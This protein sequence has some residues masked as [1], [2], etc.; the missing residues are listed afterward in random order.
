MIKVLILSYRGAEIYPSS[1]QSQLS[2]HAA[3]LPYDAAPGYP[4]PKS[5]VGRVEQ[6]GLRAQQRHGYRTQPQ[7]HDFIQQKS[8][9]ASNGHVDIRPVISETTHATRGRMEGDTTTPALGTLRTPNSRVGRA[10]AAPEQGRTC[11]EEKDKN[12][13]FDGGGV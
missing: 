7:Y 3:T 6:S 13:A 11:N 4:M 2:Q 5:R 12:G 8:R 1:S 9:H 10:C